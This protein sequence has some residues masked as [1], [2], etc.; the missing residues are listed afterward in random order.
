MKL[1]C[2]DED[3]Q[4][5]IIE[6]AINRGNVALSSEPS[7]T[8]N[9]SQSQRQSSEYYQSSSSSGVSSDHDITSTSSAENYE[10]ISEHNNAREAMAELRQMSKQV[11]GMASH[12]NPVQTM[13]R[14]ILKPLRLVH[15]H[16]SK[17]KHK[18]GPNDVTKAYRGV[19]EIA[20]YE[21]LHFASTMQSDLLGS[22]STMLKKFGTRGIFGCGVVEKK[23][24]AISFLS[25]NNNTCIPPHNYA[26]FFQSCRHPCTAYSYQQSNEADTPFSKLNAALFNSKPS[27]EKIISYLGCVDSFVLSLA[28]H[29]GDTVVISCVHSYVKACCALIDEMNAL[30]KLSKYT[31]PYFGMVDLERIKL[32][33]DRQGSM[34]HKPH[35]LLQNLTAP[36]SQPNIIDIKMG[37]QTYEPSAPLSKQIREAGKYSQQSEIGF[38]IVGMRVHI[39]SMGNYQSWDKSFGVSLESRDDVS[40]A[41][42]TFFL[43]NGDKAS[44]PCTKHVLSS[45]IK[46]LTQIKNW[47]EEENATLA[48]YAS[49]ILIVYDGDSN[50]AHIREPVIKMI[51]FAHV[52]RHS[53]GDSGYLKG[54]QNLLSILGNIQGK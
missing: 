20:F 42:E 1:D 17:A 4:Q 48:F 29:A 33:S 13:G 16:H 39:D 6:C 5:C 35:L 3:F 54:L 34:L 9:E 31:S 37:T 12:K 21:A 32:G 43:C 25:L 52:C 23:Q 40:R 49:S 50:N 14:F 2:S 46:Q 53:R 45:V 24:S 36:F 27:V 28:Y 8:L 51:D 19:R 11:G 7:N 30:E 10:N 18:D 38:R 41:F 15:D 26:S 44:A 47:F 22:Y